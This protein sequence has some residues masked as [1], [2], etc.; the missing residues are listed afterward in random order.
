MVFNA[1]R[2]SPEWPIVSQSWQGVEVKERLAE[3]LVPL[4]ELA[5]DAHEHWLLTDFELRS[6]RAIEVRDSPD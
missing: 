2:N 5:A 6:S 1:H 3:L 4:S